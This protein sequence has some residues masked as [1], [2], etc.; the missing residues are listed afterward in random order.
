MQNALPQ[1]DLG[2]ATSS[3]S[4]FR[5]IGAT[6]GA[7]VFLSITYSAAGPGDHECVRER[8]RPSLRVVA[9]GHPGQAGA[10][11]LASSGSQSALNNTA[12]LGHLNPVLAQPFRQGFASALD[13]AFLAS[14]AV[15]AAALVLALLI[16]ELPLRTTV[17]AP[18]AAPAEP[19][20][21]VRRLRREQRFSRVRR[22]AA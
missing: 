6:A 13:I 16:R 4:F 21:A 8:R 19:G 20:Q 15:M 7:A 18:S 1:A 17:A 14:A 9:A 10:L 5:Q 11:R 3:N 12:F 2:V 22:G